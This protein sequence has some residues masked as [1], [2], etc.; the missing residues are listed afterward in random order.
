MSIYKVPYTYSDFDT[1]N[2]PY[3]EIIIFNTLKSKGS[4]KIFAIVDSGAD[5]IVVPFSVG[6]DIELENPEPDEFKKFHS[7]G[8]RVS[9]INK[10][11]RIYLVNRTDKKMYGF[12]ES[13][14]WAHPNPDTQKKMEEIIK[15]YR[16]SKELLIQEKNPRTI[17]YF[18]EKI[19]TREAELK[20]I[21]DSFEVITLLG[22]PFFDNFKYIKFYKENNKDFF[23]YEIINSKIVDVRE[24]PEVI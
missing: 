3:L 4:S 19:A 24:I 21:N 9:F 1:K 13:I 7:V 17:D 14:A 6:K 2:R 23:D 18:K 22:R 16:N 10:Y 11:S 12:D 5:Q 8:E 15:D 20:A